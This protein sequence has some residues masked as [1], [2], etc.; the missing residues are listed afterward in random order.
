VSEATAPTP[1]AKLSFEEALAELETIVDRL[2]RGE[3]PLEHSIEAYE[4]GTALRRH[5]E[6]KLAQA[7]L[8]VERLV[9][10]EDGALAAEPLDPEAS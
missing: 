9:E 10:G 7:R 8:R 3:I 2:D 4:R 1:V 5:C 6:Q